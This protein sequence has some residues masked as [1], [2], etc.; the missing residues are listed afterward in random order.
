MHAN[1]SAGFP[2]SLESRVSDMPS[3][4]KI[5]R[6]FLASPG[7]LQEERQA[8]RDV[9][10]EFN[11]SWASE[12]GYQVELIGWEETVAG[13]G[14]PQHLINQDLDRCDLFLGM[15]WK[16]WGTPPDHDGE[17]S[18]GF[19]EEFE[20]SMARCEKTGSPEISLFF[21]QIPDEFMV[22]PGDDLKKVLE[23]RETIIA[24]KKILFQNFSTVRDMET[25]TRKC[26]TAYVNRVRTE[27][28]SSEPNELGTK[29]AL[30][31][32]EK[33]GE[34]DRGRESSPLSA[35]GF[36][37]LKDLVKRIR[38]PDS[39]DMLSASDVARFR[40]LANSI[41]KSGNDEMDL[42]VHDINILFAAR[43]KGI[44]PGER[45]IRSLTRLGFQ[46]LANENVPL[47]C[48]YSA[49]ADSRF[50]IAVVSSFFGAN[51]NEK[52]GAISVLTALALDIPTDD[53][54]I[55][56]DWII[57]SWFSDDSPVRVRTAALGYLAK[58]GTAG[59][60]E[61]ARKEYDRS[62][63][64]T[65]RSALEC[66]VEIL[67][68]TGQV[69]VAQ[70]LILESQFETLNADL[71]GS[72]LS[73]FEGLENPTLFLGL[74]HRNSKV[75]LSAMKSLHSRG[76]LDIGMAE[77]LTGDSDAQIRSEAIAAL[78]NLG[79]PLSEE[80][81]KKILVPP[82]KQ[83]RP[84]GLGLGIAA[85]TDKAAEELFQ[86]YQFGVLKSLSE[87]EL[88]RRVGTSLLHDDA[89]Y[90]ALMEKHFRNHADEL[91]RDVDDRFGAYFEER[92]RRMEATFGDI[93]AI[94]DLV[95]QT[96]DLEEFLRKK[97]TRK[98]LDIL[99]VVQK[100]EDL[101]RIRANIQ[102]GYAGASKLDA[103]Y[104]GRRGEWT[105][106]PMIVNAQGP[107]L[108]ATL[109]TMSHNEEF[110]LEVARAI[111]SIGKKHS[112]SDLLSLEMP[113]AILMKTIEVCAES[114]FGKI[115]RDALLALFNHES[116]GVRKAAAVLA[117]RALP[118]KRI[119]S[120]LSEYV[121]SEK[122]RYYNVI[123]WLDLGASM[124]R[125]DA[126]RVARAVGS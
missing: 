95:K 59:D 10:G 123:H 4:R 13:Y 119:K 89:A 114:R 21:K 93:S 91:R 3:T 43:T 39:L 31:G 26:I 61:I 12:L 2:A 5:I 86:Q 97:L 52:V 85:G 101:Q 36:E 30:S 82:Q 6:T 77:R 24:G 51:E 112:I 47:W 90:F 20:R 110:Q 106:I 55:K 53:D 16:R 35:E 94:L 38:Q 49:L 124:S 125:V 1:R 44:E 40:L 87:A 41:S 27:E 117:V 28:E 34:D 116:E 84:L 57:N 62:D 45:E 15:I 33:A 96:K 69:K 37:F 75:R 80:E 29:Q 48:W 99:C 66:M 78:L 107:M 32:S 98:G 18:S 63:H 92:I 121:S 109:L 58:C 102:D 83:T 111:T 9:V 19:E 113:A 71:L 65:S 67:L 22:D 25:L 122:Y 60:L 42:G 81:I 118:A 76:A 46:H 100:P 79:K 17:F 126:K 70:E 120:L 50:D 105:D 74:E 72:A 88:E 23:F 68:R 64:G 8:I 103:K 14:R 73:G 56:R 108:G 7:D 11:D 54:P 115:S 104:L